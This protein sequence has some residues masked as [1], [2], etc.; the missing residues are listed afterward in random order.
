[1]RWLVLCDADGPII[2]GPLPQGT[3]LLDCGSVVAEFTVPA[4]SGLPL[5]LLEYHSSLGWPRQLRIT[6]S[7]E[8]N[9]TLFHRQADTIAT[10]SVTLPLPAEPALLRLTYCWDAT[11][12]MS[13]I[14]AELPG[15]GQMAVARGSN[16][17]PVPHQDLVAL[18]RGDASFAAGLV[19][20]G[21]TGSIERIGHIPGLIGATP[22]RTPGGVRRI[23][24]LRAGDLVDT[25]NHGPLPIRWIGSAEMPARGSFAPVRL[26]APFFGN[27][28]DLIVSAQQRVVLSGAEVEYLFGE[29]EV[30][31]EAGRLVDGMTALAERRRTLVRFHSVLL[32]QHALLDLDGGRVDSLFVNAGRG[33]RAPEHGWLR[34]RLAPEV[35]A[36]HQ[37]PALPTLRGYEAATLL[38]MRQQVRNP[39]AA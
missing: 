29:D 21:I 37:N 16:P 24:S 4:G 38:S 11:R 8:G 1:M 23:D 25:S 18:A 22:V 14:A 32:D 15:R 3:D 27:R 13:Q 9:V 36:M 26:R 7:A 19:W 33:L 5:T 34:D 39:V 31:V 28:S 35:L 2:P 20:F 10:V 6:L 12:R 17:L 30:V